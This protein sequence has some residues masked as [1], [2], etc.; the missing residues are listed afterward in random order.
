M[1]V[2]AWFRR[3]P[4]VVPSDARLESRRRGGAGAGIGG[5]DR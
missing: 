3:L 5:S 1:I 4:A 2:V